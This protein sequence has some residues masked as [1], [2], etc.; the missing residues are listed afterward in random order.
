MVSA[1]YSASRGSTALPQSQ[2]QYLKEAFGVLQP[3]LSN[4][5]EWPALNTAPT[6]PELPPV[7]KISAYNTEH[8]A[9]AQ[10]HSLGRIT[11]NNPLACRRSTPIVNN[12]QQL[13]LSNSP[14]PSGANSAPKNPKLYKTELCRSWMDSGRC[15]YGDRCQ[16]A[17]GEGE[18]RPIP[19]HP[20]YKTEACQSYHQ[21]GY[22]PYG[23]RCSF[24]VDIFV[25]FSSHF[26]HNE[27]PHVIA[28]LVAQNAAATAASKQPNGN[29]S[30]PPLRP[31]NLMSST[32]AVGG[33]SS[34]GRVET[35]TNSLSLP[36][37][38]SS[39]NSAISA[40]AQLAAAA[41]NQQPQLFSRQF[42]TQLQ[43]FNDNLKNVANNPTTLGQTTGGGSTG[44]SPTIP[45]STDSGSESPVCSFSPGSELDD[46]IS[47][48]RRH[49]EV[50]QQTQN[51]KRGSDPNTPSEI[52]PVFGSSD[53]ESG[54][55]SS[56]SSTD[57]TMN[58]PTVGSPPQTTPTS[59]SWSPPTGAARLPVFE[60][61][62]NGP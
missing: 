10:T 25:D 21:S 46:P 60:R 14:Q 40:A 52:V 18:K 47:F 50:R 31:V 11:P 7:M 30:S 2:A 41:F 24:R 44:E 6:R 55:L 35:P 59:S 8:R 23:P 29:T 17:H 32:A 43:L 9:I 16:Y 15:N 37:P 13:L 26:I 20:K 45:S 22:C 12:S 48:I 38:V 4:D 1:G 39:N 62:S 61:L 34:T 5:S 3:T 56:A 19:R 36:S 33:R 58:S 49:L 53:V 27:E 51:N 42:Q 28:Q 57:G 54:F